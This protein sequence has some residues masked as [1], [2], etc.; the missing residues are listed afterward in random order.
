MTIE[1]APVR[2]D[3]SIRTQPPSP[4]RLSRKVLLSGALAAGGV[5]SWA[6]IAGLSD[7]RVHAASQPQAVAATTGPPE[8][9]ANASSDYDPAALKARPDMVWGDHPPPSAT[10]AAEELK[11]PSNTDWANGASLA[12]S[13]ASSPQA[14]ARAAS[15]EA[16]ARSAPIIF[17]DRRN[18]R[19]N[20][21]STDGM[22]AAS[23]SERA[24][25][26]AS[27]RS[28]NDDRSPTTL[29]PPRSPYEILAGAIIPAALLTELNSDL[30]GRVIAQVTSPVFD[31]ITGQY[32]LIPQ[33]ARLI[34]TYDSATN[35]GDNRILLAWNRIV[36][37]N[38][39][40]I[41]LKGME[42]T[43]PSGAAGLRDWTDNHL[44][45]LAGAIGLSSIMSVIANN[46]EDKRDARS[47]G[48]SIG[49]AAAQ[50]AAGAGGRI[51]ERQLQVHPTLRV[52]VGAPVRVLVTRDI[53]LRPYLEAAP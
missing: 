16:V 10:P 11:P 31:T 24:V 52:R 37:P 43:D 46:A 30:P 9:I 12:Q 51:V 15:P 35:H 29:A 36:M 13:S 41:N 40:S 6:L 27:Q 22:G 50:E 23:A 26:L 8:K 53:G 49:D 2:P 1:A 48:Q 33:G 18:A 42:A 4:K 38:G 25:F 20:G 39:W 7:Q 19:A 34:G 32:L 45:P 3:L 14:A 44:G 17:S 28:Q 5:I 21:D 47:L